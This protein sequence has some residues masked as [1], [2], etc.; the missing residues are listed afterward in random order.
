M[1]RME[2]EINQGPACAHRCPH[3]HRVKANGLERFE[4]LLTDPVLSLEHQLNFP[5]PATVVIC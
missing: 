2:W 3:V 1:E 4:R 5:L